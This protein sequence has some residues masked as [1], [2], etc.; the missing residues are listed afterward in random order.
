MAAFP[1]L[2][3]RPSYPLDPDGEIEDAILRS[4]SD[5]GYVQT[6]PRY[7]RVRRNWGVNYLHLPDADVTLLRSFEITT[8]RNGADL[9]TWTHPLSATAYTVQLTAPIKFGR[10]VA[11]GVATVSFGLKEV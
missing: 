10:K 4:P 5:G 6:R 11:G 2:S 9:F 7:T 1:T 3:K 8:L